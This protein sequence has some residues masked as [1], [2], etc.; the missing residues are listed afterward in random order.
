[1]DVEKIRELRLADPFRPFNL[2]L[3]DGRKLPVDEAY[4][5]GISPTKKFVVHSSIDGGYEVIVVGRVR[6]VDFDDVRRP[7]RPK[8]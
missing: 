1:M 5:L 3:E 7:A 8:N 4:Y 2:V 6:D